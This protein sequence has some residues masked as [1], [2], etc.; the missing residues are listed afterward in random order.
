[1]ASLVPPPMQ[2]LSLIVL[3]MASRPATHLNA[4]PHARTRQALCNILAIVL[5]EGNGRVI[6]PLV[7]EPGFMAALGKHL[8]AKSAVARGKVV[9]LIALCAEVSLS[10]LWRFVEYVIPLLVPGDSRTP[11][12]V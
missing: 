12:A 1:M 5:S 9:R 7:A 2:L 8:G 6:A 11:F 4:H 3:S 10:W